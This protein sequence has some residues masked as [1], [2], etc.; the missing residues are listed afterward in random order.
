MVFENRIASFITRKKGRANTV[1][2]MQRINTARKASQ[3]LCSF[4]SPY[5]L[6]FAPPYEILYVIQTK[7]MKLLLVFFTCHFVCHHIV[8]GF[9]RA[10]CGCTI[11]DLEN[12][13]RKAPDMS[14]YIYY[15]HIKTIGENI[16]V[17]LWLNK[18]IFKGPKI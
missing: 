13:E 17:N 4:L 11:I 10:L 6:L 16:N 14:R 3:S 5:I 18:R 2:Q 12:V 15:V 1:S 9:L 7:Q 8:V